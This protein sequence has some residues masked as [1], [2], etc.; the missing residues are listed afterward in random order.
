MPQLVPNKQPIVSQSPRIALVGE[1]PGADEEVQGTPFVGSS[2]QLLNTA[3]AKV[4]IMRTGC[5]LGNVHQYRPPGNKIE[6]INYNSAEWFQGI[7]TLRAELEAFNPDITIAFGETAMKV[8]TERTAITKWRGSIIPNKLLGKG[9]VIPTYHPAYCLRQYKWTP[10]M[11]F[12]MTKAL[13][14][15][16]DGH[17]ESK[18]VY[19]INPTLNRILEYCHE[20]ESAEIVSF[21]FETLRG[22]GLPLCLGFATSPNHSLCIPFGEVWTA[23]EE[24]E[25][26]KAIQRVMQAPTRKV[27]HNALYDCSVL[28]VWPKIWCTNLWMD[29]M[30]AIHACYPELPK[31]LSFA[32]SIFTDEPYYKHEHKESEE[33]DDEKGWSAKAPRDKLYIY[34]CKDCCVTFELITSLQK[35]IDETGSRAGYETDMKCLPLA[36]DMTLQGIKF[37][38]DQASLRYAELE[39]EAEVLQKLINARFERDINSKSPKQMKELLYDELK[40]PVQMIQGK[41]SSG[42]DAILTLARK[43]PQHTELMM[44]LKNRQIRTKQSFFDLD[45]HKD[46]RVHTG[47][48]VAGTETGRWSSSASI[49]KGRNIMNIPEDC[50]DCYVAG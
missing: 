22:N 36:L 44:L 14:I 50:R 39:Y 19:E 12:D 11:E 30:L 43:F 29:T 3:C 48:N 25:I 5:Y 16:K 37:D 23:R 24:F 28:A 47:F 38:F 10:I 9:W 26:W 27:A 42:V 33:E 34:N 40:L 13:R 7:A 18:R 2:G 46:G 49:L 20:L 41:V 21:D 32:T 31:K 35:E 6:L 8:L 1:A 4:G 45:I 17:K 15:G